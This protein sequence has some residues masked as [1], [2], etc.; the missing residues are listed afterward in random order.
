VLCQRY[1]VLEE[2]G[3]GGFGVVYRV[4]DIRLNNRVLAVKQLQI[5]PSMSAQDQQI[6]HNSFA[7]EARLLSSLKHP[8]LP[9]IYDY[10]SENG[11]SYLAMDF[12]SGETLEE[13]LQKIAPGLLPVEDT[14]W[15]GIELATVLDYLHSQQPPIIFRDLK[16]SNIMFSN[17]GQL[18]LIDFG[19]ARH[20]KPGQKANTEN[21]G[22][23]GYAS[24]EHYSRT[25]QT[26]A[27]SDIYSLGAIMHQLLS[28]KDPTDHP[29]F[30]FPT[31]HTLQL[32]GRTQAKLVDLVM[33]MLEN[34]PQ[35][36]PSSAA[37]IRQ[38]FQNM[39]RELKQPV[40]TLSTSTGSIQIPTDSHSVTSQPQILIPDSQ[41]T[42]PLSLPKAV[43]EYLYKYDHISHAIHTLSWSPDGHYLAAAGESPAQIYLW[44]ALT[45]QTISTFNA[46]ER[47]IRALAWSP[48]SRLLASASNDHSVKIW[49]AATGRHLGTY[50]QHTHW[51]HALT[52][53]PDGQLIA[54]GDACGSIHLWNPDNMHQ[55]LTYHKMHKGAI[56]C[57]A[58]SPDG[59][60][61]ASGDDEM[62]L[63]V[64]N[65]LS[66][67]CQRTYNQHPKGVVALSWSSD[68]T[69]L[70][71]ASAQR[72]RQV[73]I[74]RI[75]DGTQIQI[76]Q[77]HDRLL[78]ALAWSPDGRHIASADRRAIHIWNAQQ[79]NTLYTYHGHTTSINTLAWSPDGTYLASAGNDT[80][81]HVW[82]AI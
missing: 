13:R 17:D 19:I 64:W 35:E 55:K 20:F 76:Y 61:L 24:P 48:D 74:W 10:F 79:G 34:N 18:Y 75:T 47:S 2:I 39:L 54:S 46:H 59:S 15:I 65:K 56:S 44:E 45:N 70:A 51:V 73:H 67:D 52:W 26:S 77:A 40:A 25:L 42:P 21:L 36:R 69:L 8:N 22:T 80:T 71:S 43:G 12:I 32:Q 41:Q 31:L 1:R 33:Q 30:Q 68:S 63:H 57:L 6:A 66:G 11:S 60:L 62:G 29:L 38:E 3:Q 9:G 37:N 23:Q 82:R 58:F 27:L 16:P 28:G 78:S 49:E 72:D 5:D 4:E 53:S 14:L 50:Q 7:N 81:I